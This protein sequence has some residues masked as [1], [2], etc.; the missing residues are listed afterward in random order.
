MYRVKMENSE[1]Q[2]RQMFISGIAGTLAAIVIVALA[3]IFAPRACAEDPAGVPAT[4]LDALRS[5]TKQAMN[6][7]ARLTNRKP[8]AMVPVLAFLPTSVL[9]ARFCQAKQCNVVVSFHDNGV[10]YMDEHLDPL[11]HEVAFS[12]LIHEAVHVM[13][14]SNKEFPKTCGDAFNLER[15]A[16]EAQA[17]YLREQQ[18]MLAGLV[19][20]NLRLYRCSEDK[21]STE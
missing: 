12:I 18:N 5:V 9:Q 8:L 3:L 15:E 13:Q 14:E 17:H 10:I 2:G 11:R 6:E 16:V 21:P 19:L 7:A 20:Q 1:W 4:H